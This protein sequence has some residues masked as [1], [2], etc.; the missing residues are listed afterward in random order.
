MNIPLEIFFLSDQ[1]YYDIF[2]HNLR[3][4]GLNIIFHE[5]SYMFMHFYCF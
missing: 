1:K 2:G 3:K 4:K 5:I